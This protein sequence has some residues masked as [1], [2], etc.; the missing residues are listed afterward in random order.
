MA[1][2]VTIKAR[3]QQTW[4]QG[5]YMLMSADLVLVSELLCETID[6]RAGQTVL[7][8]ATGSGNTALAA[9]RRRCDVIGIDYAPSML[10]LGQARAAAE[11]LP[12]T[13][14]DGDAEQLPFADA[15]FDVVLSTFGVMFAPDQAQAA[16]EL[17]RV[18]R[19]GGKIGLASWTPESFPGAFRQVMA[20]YL[21]PPPG[22]PSPVRWGTEAGLRELFGTGVISLQVTQRT[23]AQR[24]RSAQHCVEHL[25]T[26][27]GPVVAAFAALDAERQAQ[28]MRDMVEDAQRF[29]RSG[30]ETFVA[31]CDYL[32]AVAIKR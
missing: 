28:L 10:V 11:R 31:P 27:F 12:V 4:A 16:R 24:Y 29:N 21:P 9:A 5:D 32:E 15:T 20:Q 14:R 13:F 22:V 26:N 18:C 17:L 30:D 23:I 1:D 6:L 3:Q 25:R 2:L 8:V 7:D 19:P